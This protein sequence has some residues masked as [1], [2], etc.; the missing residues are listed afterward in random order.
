MI[1]ILIGKDLS[2]RR[3][4]LKIFDDSNDFICELINQDKVI[5]YIGGEISEDA[6]E[7]L[8]KFLNERYE[9]LKEKK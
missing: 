6:I 8:R 9:S 5:P 2:S 4:M 3:D 1:T 7:I